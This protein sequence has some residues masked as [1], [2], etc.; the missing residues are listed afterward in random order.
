MRAVRQGASP[1]GWHSL[2]FGGSVSLITGV[3]IVGGSML[4]A[5]VG[6]AVDPA[7]RPAGLFTGAVLGGLIGLAV[8]IRGAQR[9]GALPRTRASVWA[10]LIGGLVGFG[11]AIPLAVTHLH[12]P[13]VPLLSS[14]LPGLGAAL[15][16]R[17]TQAKRALQ[18][19]REGRR[20][21][22][23]PPCD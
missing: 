22:G 19:S 1:A 17:A 20:R 12:S 8:A 11:L 21:S 23:C 14:L 4:G 18:S 6:R 16:Q 5:A 2:L 13:V 10:S 9:F 3:A 7:L 15:G